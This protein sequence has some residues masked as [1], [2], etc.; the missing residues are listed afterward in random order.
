MRM[1]TNCVKK[2]VISLFL[3]CFRQSGDD[4]VPFVCAVDNDQMIR[5]VCLALSRG[6]CTFRRSEMKIMT[7]STRVTNFYVSL[8]TL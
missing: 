8:F 1:V 7:D 3:L 4:L 5:R 6:K 2:K